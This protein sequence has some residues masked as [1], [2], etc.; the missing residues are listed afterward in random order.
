MKS[1][2]GTPSRPNRYDGY[3]IDMAIY[4]YIYTNTN[5]YTCVHTHNT[6]TYVLTHTCIHIQINLLNSPVDFGHVRLVH[7]D[8]TVTGATDDS[9]GP[10]TSDR[11]ATA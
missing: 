9:P 11:A 8:G 2:S 5:T 3:E 6:Y 10:T 1:W 7:G 4:I